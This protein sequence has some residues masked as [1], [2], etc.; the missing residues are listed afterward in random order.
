MS[1]LILKS[2]HSKRLILLNF[3]ATICYAYSM[4]TLLSL[5]E[6]FITSVSISISHQ[7]KIAFCFIFFSLFSISKLSAQIGVLTGWGMAIC[8]QYS[9]SI[10]P[11][12]TIT[13]LNYGS[14]NFVCNSFTMP[15]VSFVNQGPG[16]RVAQHNW[17][18]VAT[19][20]SAQIT[21]IDQSSTL[22]TWPFSAGSVLSPSVYA[23]VGGIEYITFSINNSSI[24]FTVEKNN[25]QIQLATPSLSVNSSTICSG[26]TTTLWAFGATNYAWSNGANT[27][28][29][30]VN[31][32]SNSSYSVIGSTGLCTLQAVYN[33]SV[34]PSPT[35]SIIGNTLICQGT[36]ATLT[37]SGFTNY[38]WNNGSITPSI[39]VN[40][41]VTSFYSVVASTSSCANI[42][43][44]TVSVNPTPTITISSSAVCNGQSFSITANS[45]SGSTY[46]WIGPNA[47]TSSLQSPSFTVA[48]NAMTGLYNLTVTSAQGCTSIAITNVSVTP[49]PVPIITTNYTAICTGTNLNLIASGGSTY[50]WFGP[51]GFSSSLQNTFI[52]SASALAAGTYTLLAANGSCTA[53]TNQSITVYPLPIPLANYTPACETTTFQLTANSSGVGDNYEW[54]GPNAFMSNSQ[55]PPPFINASTLMAGTYTLTVTDV[56]NC[57]ASIYLP[58]TILLN[59]II[60]TADVTVCIGNSATLT[61]NGALNYVWSGPNGYSAN[62]YSAFITSANSPFSKVYTVIGTAAN[63]CT[64]LAT[65]NLKTIPVP[66]PSLNATSNVCLN[67]TVSLQG[68]GGDTYQWQGPYNFFASTQNV[69]FNATNL[70]Y[71]GIYT[72][73]VLSNN[74]CSVKTTTNITIND[75]PRAELTSNITNSC[76]PFC[77]DFKFK[78]TSA[79]EITKVSWQLDTFLSDTESFPYCINKAGTYTAIGN[80]TN[81]LTC[82][83][84]VTFSIQGYPQPIADFDYL[85][86]KPIAG[87]DEVLFTDQSTNKPL[88]DWHWFFINN[89]DYSA[90]GQNTSYLF[91]NSGTYPVALV[92]KNIWGCK[93]TLVKNIIIEPDFNIFVPN[94][95]TPNQDNENE[96]FQPKGT[97]IVKYTLSIYNRW[98]EKLFE[99]V[100]FTRGW[101]G[102][103]KSQS[104]KSGVYIWK[105]NATNVSGRVKAMVGHVSLYR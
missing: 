93:D 53:S 64:S 98:G 97:G 56:N 87:F 85:P 3:F 89:A 25:F 44:I 41:T 22:V 91:E 32:T 81:A 86:K 36:T 16:W 51:N 55:N 28:S 27:N 94:A 68:F 71:S 84:T 40:P 66:T 20:I 61:A 5:N 30:S 12:E 82:A 95:F 26:Q 60:K 52:N 8:N 14:Q 102:T 6:K 92:V 24:P 101:D 74:G 13:P 78:N 15:D 17:T 80:F 69:T 57:K 73:T 11:N 29:I 18:F 103:Y 1:Q 59:P 62:T 49:F 100:D 45:S 7:K 54:L 39:V 76:V 90:S 58:V 88:I 65:A 70:N 63:S 50:Q 23:I 104:C 35:I 96:I 31:P 2:L 4:K 72:L 42:G 48:S 38:L 43:S 10:C 9:F 75:I 77:A 67:S 47:F 21:G 99:T 46:N 79:S 105:I 33:V 83:N 19:G 34:T 37:V